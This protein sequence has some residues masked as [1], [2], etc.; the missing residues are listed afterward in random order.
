[1]EQDDFLNGAVAAESDWEPEE[2][3]QHLHALEAQLG[4]V[5]GTKVRWGPRPIDLDLL[6][7]GDLVLD[8]PRLRLPHPELPKR[9]FVLEPL[10]ELAPMAVHP[11]TG[12]TMAQMLK[13]LPVSGG[14]PR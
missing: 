9:R 4:L 1:M 11:A 8:T 7:V 3:L 13:A 14:D 12:Q 6:M 2:L 5:R 10:A